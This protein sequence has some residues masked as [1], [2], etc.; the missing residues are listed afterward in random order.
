MP[1]PAVV[2]FNAEKTAAR[3][4]AARAARREFEGR[5]A[6]TYDRRG[7]T[8]LTWCPAPGW[9]VRLRVESDDDGEP[10]DQQAR[11]CGLTVTRARRGD[12]EDT[13]ADGNPQVYSNGYA[14]SFDVPSDRELLLLRGR[15][16]RD[17]PACAVYHLPRGQRRPAAVALA[18]DL[19][20]VW[21]RTFDEC[22]GEYVVSMT[23]TAPDG[24]VIAEDSIGGIGD[25]SPAYEAYFEHFGGDEFVA[26]QIAAWAAPE[27]VRARAEAEERAALAAYERAAANLRAVSA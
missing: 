7:G 19:L 25:E 10:L 1:S 11:D 5:A 2:K 16:G 6:E 14:L 17:W 23:L 22:Q 20:D 18:R 21:A 26:E 3:E 24:E 27:A 8:I 4:R 13:D 15:H 9:V 12:V